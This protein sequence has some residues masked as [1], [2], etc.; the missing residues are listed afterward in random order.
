MGN[1]QDTSNGGAENDSVTSLETI[2]EYTPDYVLDMETAIL[3]I[4]SE[5]TY[6]TNGI[7]EMVLDADGFP[8]IIRYKIQVK[9]YGSDEWMDLAVGVKDTKD[10]YK[11]TPDY[12]PN[13]IVRCV[14]KPPVVMTQ[15]FLDASNYEAGYN[16][17]QVDNLP[18]TS[19]IV[20]Y[21][22]E[23]IEGYR[24]SMIGGNEVNK[25]IIP[26][27]SKTEKRGI[28]YKQVITGMDQLG[29][30][31]EKSAVVFSGL[32]NPFNRSPI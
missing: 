30:L 4:H 23:L 18:V 29:D 15:D 3:Q 17:K 20:E 10:V 5:P 11:Y 31:Y 28:P 26:I 6:E 14:Q 13:D 9:R 12:I 8:T 19:I 24:C 32:N 21:T 1:F 25:V 27:Q 7:G 2:I 22:D 16:G